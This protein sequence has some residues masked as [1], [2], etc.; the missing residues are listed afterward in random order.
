M[1]LDGFL[2]TVDTASRCVGFG[3]K[4]LSTYKLEPTDTSQSYCSAIVKTNIAGHCIK[5]LKNEYKC[6]IAIAEAPVLL[7]KHDLKRLAD[8]S[9]TK[10]LHSWQNYVP[11]IWTVLLAIKGRIYIRTDLMCNSVIYYTRCCNQWV[12]TNRPDN[13]GYASLKLND[14]LAMLSMSYPGSPISTD[15]TDLSGELNYLDPGCTFEVKI[16]SPPKCLHKRSLPTPNK[17]FENVKYRLRES[18]SDATVSTTGQILGADLSGGYDSTTLCCILNDQGR[19]FHSFS[20]V[21]LNSASEDWVWAKQALKM[22]PNV[23]GHML[24]REDAPLCFAKDPYESTIPFT[25]FANC[26]KIRWSAQKAKSVGVTTLIGGHGGDE[27]FDIDE[28]ALFN[29]WKQHPRVT[30]NY[31]RLYK[32]FYR[33]GY[34]QILTEFLYPGSLRRR[35]HK[36]A[37]EACE[38]PNTKSYMPNKWMLGRWYLPPWLTNSRVCELKDYI[39]SNINLVKAHSS[40]IDKYYALVSDSASVTRHLRWIYQEEGIFLRTPYLDESVFRQMASID[41]VYLTNPATPKYA[42]VQ[43]MRGVVNPIVYTRNTKD[44]GIFDIYQGWEVN[45]RRLIKELPDW[46]LVKSGLIDKKTL[47]QY[48]TRSSYRSIEPIALWRTIATENAARA[49]L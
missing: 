35:I 28:N 36:Y 5:F 4:F 13:L 2:I 32:Q 31:L 7:N 47:E 10:D 9:T 1:N 43:S 20:G 15:V 40:W 49:L 24:L 25:G 17:T 44:V 26:A 18:I 46:C 14:T 8:I 34:K 11:G 3:E 16:Q 12:L 37:Q 21:G 19:N 22:L 38:L 23:T 6:I 27:L 33:W 39:I 42:L 48:I 29:T 41:P 30:S 45:K